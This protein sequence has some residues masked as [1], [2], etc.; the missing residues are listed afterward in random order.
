MTR[1]HSS[2]GISS[3]GWP[4]PPTPAFAKQPSMRPCASR[5]AA[6]AVAT[7]SASATSHLCAETFVPYPARRSTAAA[8]FSLFVPQMQMSPPACAIP[9]AMPRPMPLLPPVISATLPDRSKG[10][11]GMTALGG[12]SVLLVDEK[13]VDLPREL[14]GL[15][16]FDDVAGV[17]DR[18]GDDGSTE[19]RRK[20]LLV[21]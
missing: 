8:F 19:A 4:R 15:V 9:S 2:N 7:A 13:R 5:V 12:C 3:N 17:V 16:E 14:G 11:N 18:L 1:R 20:T 10:A 6:N 21:P